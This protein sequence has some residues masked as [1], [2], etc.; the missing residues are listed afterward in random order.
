VLVYVNCPFT[1]FKSAIM[2]TVFLQ[3]QTNKQTNK[4]TVK[5]VCLVSYH[6]LS[7]LDRHFGGTDISVSQ[8]LETESKK[9]HKA[10]TGPS[11]V[12]VFSC[13]LPSGQIG[14]WWSKETYLRSGQWPNG[15]ATTAA[16]GDSRLTYLS[17]TKEYINNRSSMNFFHS[18]FSFAKSL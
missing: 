5:C 2:T 7:G 9:P 4:Q 18:G 8:A 3:K 13:W 16:A 15:K 14:N 11:M 12:Q 6:A 1:N 17:L 10:H